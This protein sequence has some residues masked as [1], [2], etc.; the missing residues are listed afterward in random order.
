DGS[1]YAELVDV[2][3]VDGRWGEL[4]T[5]GRSAGS[6]E[7][8]WEHADRICD[9]GRLPRQ[10]TQ[11]LC[12]GYVEALERTHLVE[13]Q[14]AQRCHYVGDG[15]KP[16]GLGGRS[17]QS[18]NADAGADLHGRGKDCDADG[19][20]A[21]AGRASDGGCAERRIQLG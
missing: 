20:S 11:S 15:R 19:E 8:V 1:G 10:S 16:R 17:G 7:D 14:D 13:R 9:S 5:G 18:G 6:A 2:G 4:W 21:A 12:L 3:G